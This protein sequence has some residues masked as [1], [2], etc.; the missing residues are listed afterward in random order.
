MS[1]ATNPSETQAAAAHTRQNPVTVPNALCVIRILGSPGLLILGWYDQAAWF[2]GLFFFLTMTDWV[3]GKLARYLDQRTDIGARL[4]SAADSILYVCLVLGGTILLGETVL[5]EAGWF[6]VAM[7][8]YAIHI[9]YGFWKFGRKP[10][11][12]TRAAKICWF[13]VT[14][15]ALC[16]LGD[17]AVW[18]F[19]VTMV[20]VTLAN[21]ETICMTYILNEWRAD[22]PSVYHA[23][24]IRD[25]NRADFA[26]A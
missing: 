23:V 5:R 17:I 24:K 8:T 10:V 15:S 14:V 3:D 20:L 13:L 19:R 6:A 4:D 18:P 22:V 25:A 21:I 7:V 2:I 26:N 12:H 1:A 16:I 9:L 11:Y